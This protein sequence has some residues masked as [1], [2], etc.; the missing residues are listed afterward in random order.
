MGSSVGCGGEIPRRIQVE[1]ALAYHTTGTN[2]HLKK[3]QC[4]T[5]GRGERRTAHADVS[6]GER[7]DRRGDVLEAAGSGEGQADREG[8]STD[9]GFEE[10]APPRAGAD[11]ECCRVSSV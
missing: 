2:S 1:V 4:T 10:G 5:P 9:E 7:H 3:G 8:H 11:C 6:D